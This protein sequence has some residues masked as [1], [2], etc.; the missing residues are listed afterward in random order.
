M[1]VCDKEDD[2][3]PL[4]L[5]QL[6]ETEETGGESLADRTCPLKFIARGYS[7]VKSRK[8]AVQFIVAGAFGFRDIVYGIILLHVICHEFLFG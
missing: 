6:R 1:V 3:G 7:F 8:N 5:I 2:P 4:F